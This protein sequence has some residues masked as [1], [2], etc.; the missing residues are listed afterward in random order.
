MIIDHAYCLHKSIAG[1]WA[2]KFE[3]ILFKSFGKFYAQFGLS[4][5]LTIIYNII[6][7]WRCIYKLPKPFRNITNLG[8]KGLPSNRIIANGFEFA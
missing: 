4:R 8:F 5:G 2:N 1:S 7:L 6:V 3:T